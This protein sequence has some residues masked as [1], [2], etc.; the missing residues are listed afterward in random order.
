MAWSK[1]KYNI[2]SKL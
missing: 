1:T 2:S